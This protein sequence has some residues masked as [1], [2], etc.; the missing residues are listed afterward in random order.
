[1]AKEDRHYEFGPFAVN[2]RERVLRRNGQII[3]LP[4]KA[5][6]TLILLIENAGSVVSKEELQGKI[7]PDSFV[8]ESN[9]ASIIS[10]LRKTLED[11]PSNPQYIETVSKRGYR[12]IVPV[13][14]SPGG[15]EAEGSIPVQVSEPETPPHRQNSKKRVWIILLL[16]AAL[17]ASGIIVFIVWKKTVKEIPDTHIS[18][19]GNPTEWESIDGLL[20]DPVGDGPFDP[21][22]L[23]HQGQDFMSIAVTNDSKNVYFLLEFA[24][25]YGGGIKLFL[26]TDLDASTGCNGAEYIVFVSPTAPGANLALADGRDCTFQDDFPGAIKSEKQGRF[27]EASVSIDALRAIAPTSKGFRL[28]ADAIAPG[29]GTP[30]TVGPPATFEISKKSE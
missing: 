10:M 27:V 3:P 22:G 26:D 18:V 12:F 5:V 30:D 20:N 17:V 6:D 2:T 1:M 24:S 29:Y 28:S 15:D 8:E 7:W 25:D 16:V 11:K 4:P 14:K 19:D 13:T 23:Y 9:L 21:S